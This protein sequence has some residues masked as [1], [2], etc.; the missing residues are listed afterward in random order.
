MSF[1]EEDFK[2]IC[3][4]QN[5]IEFQ[6]PWKAPLNMFVRKRVTFGDPAEKKKFYLSR[7]SK[8]FLELTGYFK[9]S[10]TIFLPIVSHVS[11]I[12]QM[13]STPQKSI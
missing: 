12:Y 11:H 3:S 5:D 13:P 7:S 2:I 4:S 6:T 9:A 10:I 8:E 1:P